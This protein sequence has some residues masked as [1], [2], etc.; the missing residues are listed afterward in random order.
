PCRIEVLRRAIPGV[1]NGPD[2]PVRRARPRRL[3]AAHRDL[4]RDRAA[5]G[6]RELR[7]PLPRGR[8]RDLDEPEIRRPAVPLVRF[9]RHA[10]IR[11]DQRQL[12]FERLLGGEYHAQRRALPWRDRRGH[13]PALGRI[14]AAAGRS[15][16]LRL[17]C[18]E[19]QDETCACDQ[20]RRCRNGGKPAC[21]N[22]IGPPRGPQIKRYWSALAESWQNPCRRTAGRGGPSTE[23]RTIS[24]HDGNGPAPWAENPQTPGGSATRQAGGRLDP[25]QRARHARQRSGENARSTTRDEESHHAGSEGCEP[26]LRSRAP[27]LPRRPSG[28]SDRRAPAQPHPKGALALSQQRP[29]HV[30]CPGR[31]NSHISPATQGRRIADARS[32]FCRSTEAPAPGHQCGRYFRR[33][34]RTAG[35]RRIRFRAVDL[36]RLVLVA[37]WTRY[38]VVA[39]HTE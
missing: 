6:A 5:L 17:D 20:Q 39:E 19:K 15:F 31:N 27:C 11:R 36:R 4:A 24:R 2:G 35:H 1:A 26:A 3:V 28:F 34:S 32:D 8:R 37:R 13:D 12:A 14:F 22:Q 29:R 30:L 23:Y 33:V 7:L 38:R 10:S 9:D 25:A 18:R 21:W 16:G